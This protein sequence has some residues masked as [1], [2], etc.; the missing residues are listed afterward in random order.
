MKKRIHLSPPVYE[1]G[2]ALPMSIDGGVYE[3]INKDILTFENRIKEYLNT[4]KEVVAL[5]SG[6]SS[7]HMA[8]ILAGVQKGDVVF[9]QSM[10]FVASANPILYQGAVPVFVDSEVGTWNMSL[11]FL[12]E[13]FY[14]CCKKGKTPK[15]IIVTS[16]YG[17]SS[18]MDAILAFAK[19]KQIPI[20]EDSAEALGGSYQGQKLSTIGD[21]GI[22]SFNL[23]KI[24]TTAGGGILVVKTIEEK[25][26]A[27]SLATQAKE[28][29][30]Y[31][32]HETVG[33]NYRIGHL[34]AGL[35]IVQLKKIGSNLKSKKVNFHFYSSLFED[36]DGVILHKEPSDDFVS[37]HWL[38]AILVDASK[39][40]GITRE[41]IRLALEK[42]N[43][44]SRPLWKPMHMQPLYKDYPYYGNKVCETLFENGLCLPSGSN[45]TDADRDR[46][47]VS[48]K[49]L[50]SK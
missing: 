3:A 8:L 6:T 39:T 43:I 22:L 23:N 31:Y 2:V 42:D 35:G 24:V 29:L 47:S 27:I 10:T 34:N 37:N 14:E 49:T 20:I 48:I 25:E 38:S 26:K 15:A 1:Q 45:L 44:E 19:A 36:I 30:N 16:L 17:I 32:H 28:N 9:C 5:N 18:N 46:I 41:D 40:G 13:A 12:K 4:D 21:Y 11:E 7:I 50:F 33:Y